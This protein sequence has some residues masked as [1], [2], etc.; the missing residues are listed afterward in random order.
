MGRQIIRRLTAREVDTLGPGK[1]CDGDC[2]YLRVRQSG[3]R[4]WAFIYNRRGLRGDIGLG[5]A[6]SGNLKKAREEARVLY[7]GLLGGMNPRQVR[8]TNSGVPK[9]G[10]FAEK[11]IDEQIRAFTNSAHIDQW[12]A[13]H[14]QAAAIWETRIDWIN[15]DD[16]V[17]V[18]QPIWASKHTTASRLRGRLERIFDAA[19]HAGLRKGKNPAA[20]RGNLIHR[21][22]SIQKSKRHWPSLNYEQLPA[23]MEELRSRNARTAHALEITI[24]TATRTSEAI[25]SRWEEFD[26]DRRIWTLPG[27]RTKTKVPFEIPLAPRAISLLKDLNT[28]RASDYVFPSH[29]DPERHISE[30]AMD[31][32]LGRMNPKK[33]DGTYKWYDAREQRPVCVHGFRATFRQWGSDEL[34]ADDAVLEECLNHVVGSSARRSYKRQNSAKRREHIMSAFADYCSRKMQHVSL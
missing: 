34:E 4:S 9:F 25:A 23:F 17:L 27:V 33:T 14:R 19:E 28:H 30:G 16:I 11:F 31:A 24:L 12:R 8:A 2:L 7:Q 29:N 5:T 21:L 10:E 6:N 26:F 3:S 20:W 1:H 22:A 13:M 15:V 32:L 18:L